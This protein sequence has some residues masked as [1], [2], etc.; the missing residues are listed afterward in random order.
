MSA[1]WIDRLGYWNPQ[2]LREYRGRVKTR[3]VIAAIFLSGIGQLLL[4]V[5]FLQQEQQPLPQRWASLWTAITWLLPYLLFTVGSYYLVS[6]LTQEDKR[7]TLNFIRL[8]PR[9]AWQILLGKLLGVPVLPYLTAALVLPLHGVAAWIG[10]IPLSLVLSSYLM[11]IAGCVFCY[12]AAMLYA[13]LGN[14][15]SENANQQATTSIVFAAIALLVIAPLYMWWNIFVTWRPLVGTGT[16][17]TIT[18]E[19]VS[20]FYIPV[21]TQF[22][23]SHAFTL[24]NLG[25]SVYL[26]W[27]LLLRRFRQPRATILSKRQSYAILAYLEVFL[28]GWFL[29]S[30]LDSDSTA[31][32]ATA[33]YCVT[34]PL[35][36]T[37]IFG[38][39]PQR[40]ALLDWKRY[41]SQTVQSL[42]WSDKS[43][44]FIAVCVQVAIAC[45]ILLPWQLVAGLGVKQPFLTVLAF[46]VI[47]NGVLIAGAFVQ[48]ILATKI[49]NPFVWAV[50]GLGVWLVVPPTLLAL[51]KIVPSNI[52]ISNALWTFLGYPFWH[53]TVPQTLPGTFVGIAAQWIVLALLLGQ[54]QKTLKH[55]KTYPQETEAKQT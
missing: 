18:N 45:G 12:S 49:R 15:Q 6:D 35:M 21:N 17:F 54:L 20:W 9:P 29:Q 24:V 1:A 46:I 47:A 41:R 27:R 7:G 40:Q 10:G 8:S 44:A 42:V 26:M 3:T 25:I 13:L 53:F 28:L 37:L 22:L 55:L 34:L 48:L 30:S 36:L 14:A 5:A 38:V 51:L 50:G 31:G 32:A 19:P 23:V 2:L 4:L 39:C 52:P 11:L 33:V 16:I 43:P